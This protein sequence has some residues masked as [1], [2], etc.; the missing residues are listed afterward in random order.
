[1][2]LRP[3]A[4]LGNVYVTQELSFKVY[5]RVLH[6]RGLAADSWSK[7]QEMDAEPAEL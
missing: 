2:T 1:M 5:V 7:I 3:F 4:S 6:T